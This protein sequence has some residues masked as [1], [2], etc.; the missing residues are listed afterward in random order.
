MTCKNEQGVTTHS[1]TDIHQP[2]KETKYRKNKKE[3][4][5]FSLLVLITV[6]IFVHMNGMTSR[7]RSMNSMLAT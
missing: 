5:L 1:F 3:M 2:K 7:W 6:F 4:I